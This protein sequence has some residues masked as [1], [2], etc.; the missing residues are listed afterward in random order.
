[1]PYLIQ[2]NLMRG[3]KA[4]RVGIGLLILMMVSL[5]LSVFL[6]LAALGA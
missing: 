3:K 1:M 5:C 6:G 2:Q 4:N